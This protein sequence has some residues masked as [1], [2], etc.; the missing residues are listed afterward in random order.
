ME[1][2]P[3]AVKWTDN[4]GLYF[5]FDLVW[6]IQWICLLGLKFVWCW[7]NL[8]YQIWFFFNFNI[9]SL[10]KTSWHQISIIF[11][12]IEGGMISDKIYIYY[13]FVGLTPL[14]YA[15]S[16][17]QDGALEVLLNFA[18][19]CQSILYLNFL[20]ILWRSY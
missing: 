12:C 16:A 6:Q 3:E 9:S 19:V 17:G 13:L 7:L 14:H 1:L 20:K 8:S 15:A 4:T 2:V 18:K 5:A 10:I 11:S